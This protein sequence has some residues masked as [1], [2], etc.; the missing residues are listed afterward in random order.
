MYKGWCLIL[1]EH[2]VGIGEYTIS[3]KKEDVVKTFALSTCVGI[4]VYDINKKILAMAHVLLPKTIRG[5][6]DDQMAKYADTAIYNVFRE[7]IIKHNCNESNFQVT[8][9]GGI[10][11]KAGDI[12]K[13]G[14]KNIAVIKGIL[15]KKNIIYDSTNTGGRL[16]RTI[17]AYTSDGTIDLKTTPICNF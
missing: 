15:D 3:T 10:D 1:M 2:I 7:M 8:L 9:F 16:S 14:E 17:T 5:N 6:E 12:F 4:V 13:V 11:S